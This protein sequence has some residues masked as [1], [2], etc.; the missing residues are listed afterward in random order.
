MEPSVRVGT[1]HTNMLDR[2]EELLELAK[3]IM[4]WLHENYTPH[5]QV[6][7]SEE[8]A[9]VSEG[10]MAVYTKEFIED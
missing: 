5:Y 8:H 4:K 9:E 3:P 7:I 2:N 1:K 6:N 10:V